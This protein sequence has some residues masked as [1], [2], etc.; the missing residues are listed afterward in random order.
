M[1]R[2]QATAFS[3]WLMGPTHRWKPST[4]NSGRPCGQAPS[5][6]TP[7]RRCAR[8]LLR[9][10]AVS[11]APPQ[12]APRRLRRA[13]A[14]TTSWPGTWHQ[15]DYPETIEDPISALE[16]DKERVRILIDRYGVV[17]R[18]LANREGGVFSWLQLF[19]A[20]RVME[21]AGG[22]CRRSVF[23]RVFGTSVRIPRRHPSTV[24]QT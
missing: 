1:I 18:E 4:S 3:N 13:A 23:D 17:T 20:L 19:R 2:V 9:K 5:P 8:V 21:L 7:W 14:S 16:T 6:P 10:F 24:T 11:A 22:D 12:R 15:L